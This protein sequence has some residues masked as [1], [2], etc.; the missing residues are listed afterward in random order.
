MRN[1]CPDSIDIAK[2]D[3][4][5]NKKVTLQVN[6]KGHVLHAFVNGKLIGEYE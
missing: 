6:T 2:N 5:W 3:P 1:R 4:L